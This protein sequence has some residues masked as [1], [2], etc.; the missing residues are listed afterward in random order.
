MA[1]TLGTLAVAITGAYPARKSIGD[2]EKKVNDINGKM[3]KAGQG[4]IDYGNG[5]TNLG[6]E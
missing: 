3:Q 2:V 6:K 5:M 4:L 1:G